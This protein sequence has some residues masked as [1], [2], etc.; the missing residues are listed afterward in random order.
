MDRIAPRD[1]LLGGADLRQ[2]GA[3]SRAGILN[4]GFLRR[5][6]GGKAQKSDEAGQGK[7]GFHHGK[8]F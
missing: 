2:Q 6:T 1:I 3:V 4:A 7:M 8:S 5:R